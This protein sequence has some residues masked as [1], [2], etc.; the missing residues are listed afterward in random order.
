M[1]C[2]VEGAGCVEGEARTS[3]SVPMS[4]SMLSRMRREGL[5]H[6]A[7][8]IQYF[9]CVRTFATGEPEKRLRST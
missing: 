5:R 3:S 6:A 2:E 4:L 9:M 8:S 1:Q 7:F